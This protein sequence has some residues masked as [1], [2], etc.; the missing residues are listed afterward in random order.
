MTFM[1]RTLTLAVVLLIATSA[2]AA[3]P[4]A[5]AD[6]IARFISPDTLVI[7][8]IDLTRTD[9]KASADQILLW[10]NR[11]KLEPDEMDHAT[12]GLR[13]GSQMLAAA[14]DKLAKAGCKHLYILTSLF[15]VPE[16]P[17]LLVATMEQGGDAQAISDVFVREPAQMRFGGKPWPEKSEPQPGAVLFG[18]AGAIERAKASAAAPKPRAEV[19]SALTVINDQPIQIVLAPTADARRVV[20]SLF[21]RLPRE[22]GG[23]PSTVVTQGAQWVALGLD[24]GDKPAVKL[25]IQ[26]A[27]APSAKALH[28][29]LASL[30]RL[31]RA[32][33]Q[34]KPII[35]DFPALLDK[36]MP[37]LEGD[38]LVLNID[39]PGLGTLV[40]AA[41]P[42]LSAARENAKL[43][44]S[45]SHV[46]QILLACIMHANDNKNQWPDILEQ[47]VIKYAGPKVLVN[48]R[49]PDQKIGYVYHRPPAV[50]KNP[51]TLVV[52]HEETEGFNKVMVGFA[53]GHAELMTVEALQKQLKAQG[54]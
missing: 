12:R 5:Q 9:P 50:I 27:D 30:D 6:A 40:D 11:M 14:R 4:A 19:A 25:I 15:D 20:E 39:E 26:S 44:V 13:E 43:Q 32:E 8:H 35:R 45:G 46:R 7:T 18:S 24:L 29:F 37:R 31:A 48:P 2:R 54:E 49:R 33:H 1:L 42:A 3:A 38:R 28:D 41:V 52:V 53:D 10:L 16:G 23:G 17:G 36:L 22:V 47:A 21:P 51:G 34:R